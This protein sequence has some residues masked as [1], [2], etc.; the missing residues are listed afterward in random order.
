MRG[1][2][3]TIETRSCRGVVH[4][5]DVPERPLEPERGDHAARDRGHPILHARGQR[6][7]VVE[8]R[9]AAVR[10]Q[11]GVDDPEHLDRPVADEALDRDQVAA[12][13]ALGDQRAPVDRVVGVGRDHP[14]EDRHVVVGELAHL[15]GVDEL[16]ERLRARRSGAR[17]SRTTPFTGLSQ[18]GNASGGATARAR[19]STSAKSGTASGAAARCAIRE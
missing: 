10:V 4:H 11:R 17:A 5:L 12:Q 14:I 15:G 3:S 19:R 18:H 8:A 7:R 13:H 6:R 16:A 1:F 9:E 2:T